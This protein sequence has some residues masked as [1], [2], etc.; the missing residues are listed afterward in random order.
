MI[1]V[2]HAIVGAATASF[3]PNHPV[4]AFSA[5]VLS[6]FIVD[7]IPHWHYPHPSVIEDK[8]DP[9]NTDMP[10]RLSREFIVDIFRIG[11]DAL[12]G[13]GISILAFGSL[14]VPLEI[15]LLGA[16]GGILPDPLQFLYWKMRM[17]PLIT[18]QRF[19]M[20]IHADRN[21]D[22]QHLRGVSEQVALSM[23]SIIL[24]M[25]FLK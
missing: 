8:R 2:T 11:L 12:L 25:F 9:L 13:I 1:L 24:V 3:F 16:L 6:H 7:A 22:G 10:I 17:E 15:I 18:L 23:L 20:W 19:H 4:L 5:G 21:L 14:H